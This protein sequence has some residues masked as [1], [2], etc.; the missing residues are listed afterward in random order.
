M[1][2]LRGLAWGLV[3]AVPLGFLGAAAFN[4]DSGF[5]LHSMVLWRIFGLMFEVGLPL[6]LIMLVVSAV[7]S[8]ITSCS[9]R[10]V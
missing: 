2:R 10:K 7:R 1:S 5:I 8:L 3:L 9:S 6:L 4:P